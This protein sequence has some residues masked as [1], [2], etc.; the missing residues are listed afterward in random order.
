MSALKAFAVTETDDNTGG[1]VFARHAVTARRHGANEYAGGEFAYVSCRRA[2]W[3]DRFAENQDPTISVMIA[4]GWHFECQGCGAKI[5]EDW[6]DEEGL[7]VEGVIGTQ[8]TSVY[9]C[10]RCKWKSMKRAAKRKEQEQLAIGAYKAVVLKR[11]PDAEFCDNEPDKY[12]GHHHA[13][14]T[15]DKGAWHWGQVVISFKFPGMQI[16]PAH[17]SRN[18][19]MHQWRSPFIG[20]VKPEYTCC[21][22]DR[23]AFEAWANQTRISA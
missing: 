20:P 19:P 18:E 12:R 8:A 4:H 15:M 17:Y 6:L 22:G 1:I 11:F 3:A 10:A 7:P 23:E 2:P 13:Y 16:A 14:V 9:C 21:N 5:D